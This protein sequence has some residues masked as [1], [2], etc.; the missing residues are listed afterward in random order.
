MVRK[1]AKNC[2]KDREV[3][4]KKAGNRY[5]NWKYVS[6]KK[7]SKKKTSKRKIS[8]E[9][10]FK[11][12][13]KTIAKRLLWFKEDKKMRYFLYIIKINKKTLK[14]YN[15]GASK[16]QFHTSKQLIALNLVNVNLINAWQIWT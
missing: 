3:L 13:T 6:E 11:W 1:A 16:K 4:S 12:K 5:R 7:R 10:W 15:V 8:Y 14:L 9:Y 2:I